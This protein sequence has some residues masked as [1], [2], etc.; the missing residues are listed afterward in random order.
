[1]T[2][3]NFKACLL[4]RSLVAGF[5]TLSISAQ[6]AGAVDLPWL[7]TPPAQVDGSTCQ[8]YVLGMALAMQEPVAQASYPWRMD[9]EEELRLL[10]GTIRDRVKIAM[11][12]RESKLPVKPKNSE[13]TRDD[14]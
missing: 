12:S 1:M 13:S 5:L 14:W 7:L 3:R 4:R 10:E 2:L 6:Y 11:E 8:S 9:N